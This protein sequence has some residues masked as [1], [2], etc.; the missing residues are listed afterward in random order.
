MYLSY[1]CLQNQVVIHQE[2]EEYL[3]L[4]PGVSHNFGQGQFWPEAW[5]PEGPMAIWK[6]SAEAFW[7]SLDPTST[8]EGFP[9]ATDCVK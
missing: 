3:A 8:S 4:L 5:F 7:Y 9:S 1:I 2:Q 6:P